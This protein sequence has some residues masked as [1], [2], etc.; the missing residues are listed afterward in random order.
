MRSVDEILADYDLASK[1]S[2]ARTIPSAWYTDPRIADLERRAVFSRTWQAVGRADQ[3]A[4]PGQY[5]TATVA[6]EPVLVVRGEGGALRGFFN[7][8]RHHAAAVMTEPCGRAQS[9]RCPY[10]GWT[11]GLDG[12][13]KAAPELEGLKSFD[14]ADHGLV[15]VSV[16]LWQKLV[17]V[18]LDPDPAPI[19]EHV[20][21]MARDIEAL[22]LDGLHFYE[23]RVFEL[24]CNWKVFVD[25]YLDG[26]YHVPFLHKGLNSVLDFK[27]YTIET[28]GRVCL[29]K[30]RMNASGGE[31]RTREVRRGEALYYWVYPNLMLNWYEGYL[32]TNLVIPLGIDRTAVL[33]DFYFADTSPPSSARNKQSVDVSERIQDEDHAICE[34]VQRGLSSRAYRAGRLSARREAGEHLFHRL[35][36]ADLRA[37]LA[38]GER[39]P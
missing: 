2:E 32:D 22:G 13:L 19:T 9:L 37:G 39:A 35:L 23:R 36:C 38:R 21:P 31:E 28:S 4:E 29:Q 15:P 18:H 16:A 11:Y 33:F 10:H 6:G 34:S 1:L 7:V 8:C 12:S 27:S 14:L 5:L 26:G 20:G 25:N 17:F 3:V 24:R 30:S